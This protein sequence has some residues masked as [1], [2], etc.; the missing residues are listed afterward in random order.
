MSALDV[1]IVGGGPSGLAAAIECTRRGLSHTVVEKGTVVDAIGR[2]PV[3]MV[4]FT[5]PELLEIGDL[6]L[7]T[8]NEKPVRLEALKYYRKV[9]QHYGLPLRLYEKVEEVRLDNGHFRLRT[10]PRVGPSRTYAARNVLI[11]TGYYDT[12]NLLGVPGEDLPKVSHYYREA[13]PYFSLEVAVIG[14]AN[15]AAEA[16]LELY[17]SGAKVTL[18][19]RR[20][21]LSRHIKYW[22]RPD[23]ENRIQRGEIR[24]F[25][26]TE[27]EEILAD[28]LR[29]KKKASGK[30][31][32]I[33][34]D[35]VLALTGYHA[36]FPFLESMGMRIDRETG[37]PEHDPETYETNV[38]GLYVAGGLVAGFQTNHIFIENGRLHGAKIV[39]HIA[40]RLSQDG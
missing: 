12:P 17:R 30:R 2:F 37:K 9:A 13:H 5:T 14:G 24:A 25:L 19:H 3:N 34:N 6:P 22:V 23:I 39:A 28:R 40:S 20:A 11:A 33:P 15:S 29:L 1:A 31:L 8:A 32:E 16:A 7:V 4:F 36:D 10:T 21:E 38:P 27:V 26:E 18:I 35:F